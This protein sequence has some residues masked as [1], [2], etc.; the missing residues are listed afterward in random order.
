MPYERIPYDSTQE[1][2]KDFSLTTLYLQQISEFPLL[3]PEA[4]LLL[5]EEINAGREATAALESIEDSEGINRLVAVSEAGK[6]AQEQLVQANLRF[7]VVLAKKYIGKGIEFADLIQEGNM[8]LMRAAEKF[9]YTLGKK[10]TTYAKWWIQQRMLRAIDEQSRTIALPVHVT[11]KI[12]SVRRIQRELDQKFGRMSTIAEI[13]QA[14]GVEETDVMEWIQDTWPLDSLN[15]KIGL[16][17]VA[18]FGEVIPDKKMLVEREVLKNEVLEVIEAAIL[19][20][21]FQQQQVVRLHCGF[22]ETERMTYKEIARETGMTENEVKA[23]ASEASRRL[24]HPGVARG[25]RQFLQ[26]EE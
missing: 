13:A 1:R 18:E 7:V 3:T 26:T 24:R 15:R 9:D 10:F 22:D 14:L 21:T 17:A 5:G 2:V 23:L 12:A 19:R 4:E 25:L 11:D 8:G 16:Q 6:I 20:L